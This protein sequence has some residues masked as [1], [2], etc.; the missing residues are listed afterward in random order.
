MVFAVQGRL[1]G[2]SPHI[3]LQG[4]DAEA[5]VAMAQDGRSIVV[6]GDLDREHLAHRTREP[7]RIV[8]TEHA[9]HAII[10][11]RAVGYGNGPRRVAVD[12]GDC[13]SEPRV[14]SRQP[15]EC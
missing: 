3:L 7:L 5:S 12:L 6:M 1:A 11:D 8:G 14:V 2:E 9:A 4:G 15:G 10:A 13:V